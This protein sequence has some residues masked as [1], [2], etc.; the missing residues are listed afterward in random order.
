MFPGIVQLISQIE[1]TYVTGTQIEKE[2]MT[3]TP[4]ALGTWRNNPISLVF[5]TIDS[6]CLILNFR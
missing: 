4:E 5:N 2:N 6:F 3:S 1:Y